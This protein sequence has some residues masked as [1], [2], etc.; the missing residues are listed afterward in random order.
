MWLAGYW[1]T[2]F[3]TLSCKV[4]GSAKPSAC[5]ID[6]CDIAFSNFLWLRVQRDVFVL[7]EEGRCDVKECDT[8]AG[9]G[10][11]SSLLLFTG[12]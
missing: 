6:A 12:R 11:V 2:G 1:N 10:V 9:F 5:Y 3:L 7:A 4:C 8:P